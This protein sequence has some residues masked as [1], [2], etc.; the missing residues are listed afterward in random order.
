M[1]KILVPCDFSD[2][3]IQ[4]FRFACQIALKSKGEI[5]LLNIVEMPALHNSLLV[6]VQS[7]ESAFLKGVKSKAHK[8]FKKIT[9]KWSGKLKV[10]FAVEHGSV[11]EGIRKFASKKGI[12]LVVMGTHGSSGFREFAIGSNAEKVVRS[13]RIPVIAVK[14]STALSSIKDIVFPTSLDLG[15]KHLVASVKVLQKFLK[16]KLHILYVNCPANF[17]RDINTERWL[18]DL[19]KQSR[20]RNYTINIYNDTD[21]ERGIIDFSARFKNK[22]IAMSTHGRKGL[23]HLMMGSI[24]EDVVNRIDCPIWTSAQE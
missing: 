22:M 2:T 10:H 8:N 7:Y 21:E 17:N 12:D 19:T 9:D 23:S 24:A 15:K 18:N 16:A 20:F 5:F 4:A 3:A 1:K 14:K 11:P 6:P 13:S